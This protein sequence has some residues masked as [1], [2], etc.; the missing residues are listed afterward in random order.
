MK[1]IDRMS[2]VHLTDPR[3]GRRF[4]AV[5]A[6]TMDDGTVRLRNHPCEFP[7]LHWGDSVNVV[8]DEHG[9]PVVYALS[10]FEN[11]EP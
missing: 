11:G 8:T 2:K 6:E 4:E 7:T 9:D 5:W 3:S 10:G 1:A